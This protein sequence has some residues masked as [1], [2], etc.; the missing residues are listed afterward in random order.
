MGG[1]GEEK[2]QGKF[3]TGCQLRKWNKCSIISIV[4]VTPVAVKQIGNKVNG[5]KDD[6]NYG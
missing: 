6:K 5:N 1:A 2:M 4:D 3:C